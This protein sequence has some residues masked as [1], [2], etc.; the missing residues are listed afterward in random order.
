MS[1]VLAVLAAMGALVGAALHEMTHAIAAVLVGGR[2]E[3]VGWHGGV[4]RGGPVVEWRSPD[5]DRWR[6]R[7][8]G[9]APAAVG[10][11]A[12]TVLVLRWP[13]SEVGFAAAGVVAGMMWSSPEDLS[14]D[15]ARSAYDGDHA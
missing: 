1:A 2:V 7:V 4:F 11:V 6:P 9:L 8:V 15:R 12:A 13:G 5:D 3:R 10:I 14:V